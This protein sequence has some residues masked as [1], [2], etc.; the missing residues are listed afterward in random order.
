MDKLKKEIAFDF[1][2]MLRQQGFSF[3]LISMMA[4]FFYLQFEK[5]TNKVDHCNDQK[6][7]I[8]IQTVERN[9]DAMDRNAQAIEILTKQK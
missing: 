3:I 9:T 2:K 5:L 7:E 8:L 1:W 4:I 6:I